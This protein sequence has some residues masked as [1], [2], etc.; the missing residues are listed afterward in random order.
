MAEIIEPKKDKKVGF[1][2]FEFLNVSKLE[3][4]MQRAGGKASQLAILAEYDKLGGAIRKAGRKLAMGTFYDFEAR[5]P[6]TGVDLKKLGE[7]AYD[8]EYVLVRKKRSEV[9]PEDNLVSV[10]D[11]LAKVSKE[12]LAPI[13]ATSSKPKEK[14]DKEDK[15][16]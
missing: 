14:K 16:R 5:K 4:A 6:R 3:L 7:D 15:E 10:R 1:E 2:D 9:T 11:K 8:D 12:S 13:T